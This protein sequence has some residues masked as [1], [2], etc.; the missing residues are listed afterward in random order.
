MSSSALPSPPS[1]SEA[2]GYYGHLPSWPKL[3]ARTGTIPWVEPTWDNEV[4]GKRVLRVA[5]DHPIARI[6][7]DNLAF[8]IHAILD[9]TK[10]QWTSTDVVR[11]G[12]IDNFSDPAPL[13]LWIGVIPSSLS[14]VDGVVVAF[15]CRN[16]L[17]ENGITDVNVEIR[18]SVVT[19]SA[20]AGPMLFKTGHILY[21]EAI[22]NARDPLASTLGI[23]ICAQ[24]TPW[25]RGTG[26]FFIS[27]GA[28]S[29]RLLLVTARHVVL[30][31]DRYKNEFFRSKGDS[32]PR[33]DIMVFNDV[34]FNRYLA[35]IT[36]AKN[37]TDRE[38]RKLV[39]LHDDIATHWD[40]PESRVIGHV[41][42]SPPMGV[43]G[44]NDSRSDGYTEDWAVIEIDASKVNATNFVGNTIYLGS[45]SDFYNAFASTDFK[46]PDDGLLKLNGTIS[47]AK[48]RRPLKK[49]PDG[50]LVL[51]R[52]AAT[53]LTLGR[54]NNICSYVRHYHNG[55]E[56]QTSKEWAIIQWKHR[57]RYQYDME[58]RK[59]F[60][61]TGDSGSVVVD[62]QG[63][64]GG[65][66]T[67]G[68]GTPSDLDISY[69]TPISFLLQRMREN[70]LHEP[71]PNP[72]L[73]T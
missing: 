43:G 37:C 36:S 52:G 14:G 9:E 8:K 22:I 15:K 41:V 42:L 26:G 12:Y 47:D 24:S 20:G 35:S 50:L 17:E 27:E 30:A 64:I 70:G 18:E 65:L 21:E 57:K 40:T 44:S 34:A 10:V 46:Y 28:N 38:Y 51:K 33:H 73:P 49:D 29:E 11:I 60:S 58:P 45:F 69:A 16:L 63:R 4:S 19:R 67:G 5:G 68:A 72:V 13:V 6:W 62:T 56:V 71:N 53:G 39:N 59:A 48:M 61:A 23:S 54:A 66:L 31:P 1:F 32:Q 25:T 2:Q 3:V 7:E 55:D